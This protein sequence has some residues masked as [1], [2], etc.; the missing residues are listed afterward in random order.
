M[1]HYKIS[2]GSILFAA[3][4]FFQC[5]L[6]EPENDPHR[7]RCDDG[8]VKQVGEHFGLSAFSYPSTEKGGLIVAG[9][10]KRWPTNN[11]RIIAA[12]AYDGGIQ[13]EKQLLLALVDA[14]NNQ[15]VAS[16]KGVIPEDAASEVNDSS[17]WLDTAPYTLSKTTRAFGLGLQ[18]FLDRC[19]Y[20]G[21]ADYEFTLYVVDGSELRPILS[22]TLSQ[23]RYGRGNR[24]GEEAPP[25]I[26]A[27]ILISVEKTFSNG[28]A[29][30]KLW[31]KSNDKRKPP[32][33]VVKYNGKRYDLAPWQKVFRL[34]W[35]AANTSEP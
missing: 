8:V 28:Y 2:I 9:A 20:E 19:G 29:D 18:T 27:N 14:S 21:G 5:A 4:L 31:A 15:I 1:R 30:L 12:F 10:C 7:R 32:S 13:Y 23:W 16:Y 35:E 33:A 3:L 25:R 6:A 26:D 34:W 17:L 22:E 24:C 11:S